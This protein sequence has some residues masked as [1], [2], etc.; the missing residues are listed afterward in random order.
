MTKEIKKCYNF[1]NL[2]YSAT[3]DEIKVQQK[4]MIKLLRAKELKTGKSYEKKIDK[5]CKNTNAILNYINVNG[6]PQIKDYTFD[7]S[8]DNIMALV[9]FVIIFVVFTIITFWIML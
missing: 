5:I 4:V 3:E 2:K 7:T 9:S 1:M 8:L 6:V